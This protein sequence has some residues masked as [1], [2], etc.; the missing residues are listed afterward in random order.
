MEV[1][2]KPRR[3]CTIHL[4]PELH[5][6]LK[7]LARRQGVTMGQLIRT[8]VEA[9]YGLIDAID[10]IAPMDAVRALAELALPVGDPSTMKAESCPSPSLPHE[11]SLPLLQ[12]APQSLT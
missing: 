10:P 5:G 7:T 9:H 11:C 3:T 8:A 2:L 6:R 12:E 1:V 4:T